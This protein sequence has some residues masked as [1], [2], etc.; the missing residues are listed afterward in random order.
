MI[1][2]SQ[3]VAFFIFPLCI[4]AA[5]IFAGSFFSSFFQQKKF[6]L[7]LSSDSIA[8]EQFIHAQDNIPALPIFAWKRPCLPAFF[9]SEREGSV[10]E[11][12]G[13]DSGFLH[14]PKFLESKIFSLGKGVDESL[15]PHFFCYPKEYY[16]FTLKRILC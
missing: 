13:R 4:L 7:E 6:V 10:F 9:R 2:K 16:V 15:S 14:R 8:A 12:G 5:G 3:T 1:G 11:F